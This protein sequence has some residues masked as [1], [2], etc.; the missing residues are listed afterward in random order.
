MLVQEKVKVMDQTSRESLNDKRVDFLGNVRGLQLANGLTID[1]CTKTNLQIHAE[2][3]VGRQPE[4]VP[5]PLLCPSNDAAQFQTAALHAWSDDGQCEERVEH[6]NTVELV[7]C[8]YDQKLSY[9]QNADLCPTDKDQAG[10]AILLAIFET[11]KEQTSLPFIKACKSQTCR[12]P[13]DWVKRQKTLVHKDRLQNIAMAVFPT[14]WTPPACAK[15][16]SSLQSLRPFLRPGSLISKRS[17]PQLLHKHIAVT[18]S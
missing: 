7:L 14:I 17:R 6:D 1:L 11:L 10:K 3:V 13:G 9:L 4:K 8:D 5:P 12:A 2:L 18:R 15:Q 16:L